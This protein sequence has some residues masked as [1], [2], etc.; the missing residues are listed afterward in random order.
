MALNAYSGLFGKS[1]TI[2]EIPA[3]QV[4][5]I[6]GVQLLSVFLIHFCRSLLDY[7]GSSTS[8]RTTSCTP[9]ASVLTC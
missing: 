4:S 7:T 8:S 3:W 2:F 1:S 6:A 5:V 9:Q